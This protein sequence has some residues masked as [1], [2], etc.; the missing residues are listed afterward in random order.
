MLYYFYRP[1]QKVV[2]VE[3]INVRSIAG[4]GGKSRSSSL[5]QPLIRTLKTYYISDLH[6]L[7]NV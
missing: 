3:I 1:N 7:Y 4:T 5:N 2:I 6:K